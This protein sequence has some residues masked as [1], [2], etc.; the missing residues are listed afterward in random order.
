MRTLLLVLFAAALTASLSGQQGA[1]SVDEWRDLDLS[2]KGATP[3]H[4]KNGFVPDEVTA[5]RIAEAVAIAQW[6]EKQISTER[7][8][9]ARLRGAIWTV[10][11]TLPK[12]VPGGTAVVQ[13]NKMTGT[14]VFA[15]HQ[16]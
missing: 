9:K 8:F 11:G 3:L 5:I 14:V 16:Q 7:P 13:L 12:L 1:E 15:V 10:K 6:G 4:P 2:L